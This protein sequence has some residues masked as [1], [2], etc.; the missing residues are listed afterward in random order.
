MIHFPGFYFV[1]VYVYV[2]ILRSLLIGLLAY[3][4]LFLDLYF[5]PV[6]KV[7]V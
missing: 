4:S 6:Y 1:Y 5:A 3:L 7:Y 2:I